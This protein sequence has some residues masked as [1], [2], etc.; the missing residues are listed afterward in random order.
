[1]REHGGTVSN[2]DDL[3]FYSLSDE[4]I[5]AVKYFRKRYY[6][7]VL[8]VLAVAALLMIL[9]ELFFNRYLHIN[10]STLIIIFGIFAV[11]V[12]IIALLMKIYLMN[13]LDKDYSV[14]HVIIK[15][16]RTESVMNL[17][18]DSHQEVFYTFETTD[19]HE[20]LNE[21]RLD[22]MGAFVKSIGTEV[23]LL[24][25]KKGRYS[26]FNLMSILS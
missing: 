20:I 5:Q 21:M 16:M 24:K 2:I 9:F 7:V 25:D 6:R 19:T 17:E 13:N 26:I 1:M 10:F 22:D 12:C 15:Y 4:D 8:T 23:L 14:R 18:G 3:E 11:S